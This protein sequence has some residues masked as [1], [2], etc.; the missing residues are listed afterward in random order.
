LTLVPRGIEPSRALQAT[1]VARGLRVHLGV[2]PSPEISGP[3]DVVTAIDVI[4]HVD[5][6]LGLLRAI[7]H[8]RPKALVY[9]S[10]PTS[11][12]SPRNSVLHVP[13]FMALPVMFPSS[14]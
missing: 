14:R 8:S 13:C 3:Y 1:A 6:P 9:S 11:A 10:R 2:I 12:Q 4:E 7:I 5:K